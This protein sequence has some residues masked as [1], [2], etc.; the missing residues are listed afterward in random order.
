MRVGVMGRG[1][2]HFR[3]TDG[4]RAIEIARSGGLQPEMLEIVTKDGTVFRVFGSKAAAAETTPEIQSAKEWDEAIA[5]LKAK[6]AAK[7]K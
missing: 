4:V 3:K 5:Q 7:A 6:G 1:D 2:N